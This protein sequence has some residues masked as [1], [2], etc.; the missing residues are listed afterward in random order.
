MR[1]EGLRPYPRLHARGATHGVLPLAS[2][3]LRAVATEAARVHLALLADDRDPAQGAVM[4]F[5]QR[6]TA[7]SA[8]AAS[9]AHVTALGIEGNSRTRRSAGH[10]AISPPCESESENA[11]A[12]FGRS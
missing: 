8:S 3:R 9:E 5:R 1:G 6:S 11:I 2:E 10:V 12:S 4:T 7:V